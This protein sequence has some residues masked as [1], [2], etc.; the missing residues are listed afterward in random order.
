MTNWP[1]DPYGDME[2]ILRA[3]IQEVRERHP[4]EKADRLMISEIAVPYP[5]LTLM[6]R[7]DS[8]NAAA[9]YRVALMGSTLTLDM[10][11]HHFQKHIRA[12][13]DK[14]WMVTHGPAT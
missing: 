14:G 8:C 13:I 3:S 4:S 11:G 6:D 1:E 10:C 7:C 5:E 2:P 9:A 12:L